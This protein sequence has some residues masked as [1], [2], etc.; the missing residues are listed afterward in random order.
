MRPLLVRS[1]IGVGSRFVGVG[2]GGETCHR[3][4]SWLVYGEAA[5]RLQVLRRIIL[6]FRTSVKLM[7][8]EAPG[9]VGLRVNGAREKTKNCLVLRSGEIR[10][11]R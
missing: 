5:A 7:S 8:A 10:T 4:S 9:S 2:W 6:F 1:A 3:V 11:S